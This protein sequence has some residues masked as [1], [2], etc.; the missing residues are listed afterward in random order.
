M[1]ENT[2]EGGSGRGQDEGGLAGGAAR[3]EVPP[4]FAF[5]EDQEPWVLWAV[6]LGCPQ[7]SQGAYS[8][9][10]RTR[11]RQGASPI[12]RESEL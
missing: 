12:V 2:E 9:P 11:P 4:G 1:R 3:E 8:S 5:G 6:P 7:T 10:L